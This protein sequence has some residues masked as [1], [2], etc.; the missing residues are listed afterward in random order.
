M[1]CPDE[2]ADIC[3]AV[4]VPLTV[5]DRLTDVQ[6]RVTLRLA[7]LSVAAA[8]KAV[9]EDDRVAAEVALRSAD[10]FTQQV[11]RLLNGEDRETVHLPRP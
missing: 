7:L 6:L 1:N 4:P 8:K 10:G 11:L 5:G 3:A 2:V 9:A